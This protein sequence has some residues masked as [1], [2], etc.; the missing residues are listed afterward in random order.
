M[1][2]YNPFN[3]FSLL[4]AINILEV[5]Q[6]NIVSLDTE[7]QNKSNSYVHLHPASSAHNGCHRACF[8]HVGNP[9]HIRI[10]ALTKYICSFPPMI[11]CHFILSLRQIKPAGSSWAS[12]NQ[13]RSLRF[14]GNMGQS[15]QFGGEAEHNEDDLIESEATSAEFDV[16]PEAA[17]GAADGD[18]PDEGLRKRHGIDLEAQKVSTYSHILKL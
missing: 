18:E 11:V 5:I 13:S 10:S 7:Y 14:V 12:C 1:S 15:L 2:L 3:C 9:F 4:L 8:R 6:E 16:S 17:S